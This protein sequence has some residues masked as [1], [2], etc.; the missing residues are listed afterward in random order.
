[1]FLTYTVQSFFETF[2]FLSQKDRSVIE[3]PDEYSVHVRT[4]RTTKE[5]QFDQV[6]TAE[7]SQEKVFEDTKVT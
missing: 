7:H 3:S 4:T 1:M 2:N 6:F 5:Y